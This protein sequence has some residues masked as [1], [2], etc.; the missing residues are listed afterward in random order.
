M[1]KN[2]YYLPGSDNDKVFWL[3]N[4]S[5]KI[6][7]YATVL[8]IT[9]AE[10]TSIQK[11]AAFFSYIENM[12]E[13]FKQTVN[14][15]V[16]YKELVK[17]ATDLQH[18]GAL[19]TVPVLGTAP[20]MISEGVFDRVS[21]LVK[22]IKASAAYTEAMGHD[23]GI[24]APLSTIDI[25]ALQPILRVKIEGGKP[26]IRSNK[27][28]AHAM[29]LYVDRHDGAGFKLIDR[30]TKLDFI[31]DTELEDGVQIAEFS[32]KGIFVIRNQQVGIMSNVVSVLKKA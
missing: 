21:R 23:L 11:D 14:N 26:R 1:K 17:K 13:S 22:R 28:V 2:S 20:A 8:N 9:A 3:N 25:S 6:G 19:P 32:Y 12:L 30:L 4:F 7:T 31:D 29:D 10:V 18:L 24:I 27:S 5:A 15:I 16:G